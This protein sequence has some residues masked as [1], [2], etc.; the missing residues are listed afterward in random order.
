MNT[1]MIGSRLA[2]AACAM[3]LA[4]CEGEN[5]FT[6]PAPAT[7]GGGADVPVVLSLD[8]PDFV[9]E[10]DVLRVEVEATSAEGITV[11]DV[12]VEE[13]V[14]QRRRLTFNPPRVT[15]NAFAQFQLPPSL[16]RTSIVVRVEVEDRL[17][18]RS[19]PVEVEIPVVQT[20]GGTP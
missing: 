14:V 11:L 8:V 7:G 10:N 3:V 20:G 12:T 16:T 18:S 6:G 15:L 17:G 9:R 19:E 4:G 2:L 13:G 5:L 1:R